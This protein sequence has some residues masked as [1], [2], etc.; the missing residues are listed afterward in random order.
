MGRLAPKCSYLC[1]PPPPKT[2]NFPVSSS[3]APVNAAQH[4]QVSCP[5]P[6]LTAASGTTALSIFQELRGSPRRRWTPPGLRPSQANP[7]SF[8]FGEG[9]KVLSIA[10]IHLSN[11]DDGGISRCG[12]S[13][14]HCTN[15]P[16]PSLHI[17]CLLLNPQ[18]P[19]GLGV[20]KQ[21][22]LQTV[23]AVLAGGDRDS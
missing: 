18:S 2:S 14:G 7:S 9:P 10:A 15:S 22:T 17:L 19:L 4:S 1:A 13:G 8:L 6:G 12:R 3:M 20:W 11:R 16:S 23:G 21:C 5:N